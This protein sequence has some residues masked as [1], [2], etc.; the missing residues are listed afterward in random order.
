MSK[1]LTNYEF[2]GLVQT[3]TDKY[4]NKPG[5]TDT[6]D[7]SVGQTLI[8]LLADVSDNLHY[9]LERRSQENYT[10]TARLVSSVRAAVSSIGYRPRRKVSSTGTMLLELVDNDGNPVVAQGN[11]GIPY[12]KPIFFDDVE[13]VVNGD[14]TIPAGQS[15]VELKVKQGTLESQTFNFG[16]EPY[17]ST[18]YIEFSNHLDMEEYSLQIRGDSLTYHDVLAGINGLRIRAISYADNTM[19]VY[20]LKFTRNGLRVVFGDDIFGKKPKDEIQVSWIKSDGGSVNI[21]KTG[22][23]FDFD[24]QVLVDDVLVTPQNE[25]QYR[26]TNI[27]PIR[28]GVDE[29]GIEEIRDNVTA[30]V[31][32]NDRGVTN[33]DYEFWAMRSGIGNIVDMKAYG[34]HETNQLIFTMNNVY[35]TYATPDKLDL[36]QE[37]GQQLRSY[38]DVIKTNTTHMVFRP[39]DPIYMGLTI[40]FRRHESLPIS[41]SQLYRILVQRV[42]DYFE[43]KRG[44]IGVGFQHSEFVE[45]LQNL[46]VEFN[47]IEYAMTDFVKV[48]A[49]GMVPFDIPQPTYDGIVELAPDYVVIPNDVWTISID[50]VPYS[51]VAVSTDTITTLVD[52]MQAKI[53]EGTSLMLARPAYNQIRI[54]HPKDSGFYAI[55]VGAGQIGSKTR[56]LQLIKIPRPTNVTN[57]NKNQL[58]PGT[59]EIVD[60]NGNLVMGDDGE[61]L[62]IN[63]DAGYPA[64]V[65]DYSNCQFE[66]PSIPEGTYYV[67]FQQ[68]DYQNFQITRESLIDVMPFRSETDNPD[69]HFFSVLNLL[70]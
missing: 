10:S 37:Q 68:D 22:L 70:R 64:I 55:T 36:N 65:V 59:V 52:K 44:R 11:I 50:N 18:N 38:L 15:S 9:K 51:V 8:Q 63:D 32:A 24:E 3:I 54:K 57:P 41:D 29:E 45:Y 69:A 16:M 66:Y 17:L 30:F 42:N 7:S 35:I 23:E 6:Y 53:F 12:G 34:E 26:L 33:F 14:Y 13:M 58:V 39:V 56:F 2:E 27:T 48:Q 49:T 21:I 40:D 61:G 28:G 20:D 46:R 62:L 60:L 31:R 1:D 4:R 25:Y 19:P 43:I 67:M 47:N 5:L